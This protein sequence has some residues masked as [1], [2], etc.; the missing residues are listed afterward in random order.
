VDFKRQN[1]GR[2]AMAALVTD[3]DDHSAGLAALQPVVGCLSA[4]FDGRSLGRLQGFEIGPFLVLEE[5]LAVED[6]EIEPWP[7]SGVV[8]RMAPA[9]QGI[10]ACA[11]LPAPGGPR[12]LGQA[13]EE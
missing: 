2:E 7:G 13:A 3:L 9:T 6:V 11:I 4:G 12:T 8:M 1:Q 10:E 5:L